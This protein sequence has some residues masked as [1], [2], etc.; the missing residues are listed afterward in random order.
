[1]MSMMY[2][3]AAAIDKGRR[4]YQ[5]DAIAIN[6][7][8]PEQDGTGFV[9]LADGMGGHKAGGIASQI[10]VVKMSDALKER[11]DHSDIPESEIPEVLKAAALA[12]NRSIAAYARRHGDV[13][14]MGTTVVVP[15]LSN[16]RLHWVSVGDSPLYV[17]SDDGGLNQVN[18]DHSMGAQIDLLSRNGMM[19]EETA[20]HHP[21]R[22]CLT[23]VLMGDDI[24]RIDCGQPPVTLESGNIVV[25]S[26]DGLQFLS[27]DRISDILSASRNES[28]ETIANALMQAIRDLDDPEQDNVSL[29]VIKVV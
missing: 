10:A 2:D 5:E 4:D 1:M 12:A 25:V 27:H 23:S 16:G 6:F 24:P 15:V 14:G 26:S 11:L 22:N 17:F 3:V 21:E 20:R 13:A 28:S 29:A 9:V 8:E 19:D 18:E 7:P